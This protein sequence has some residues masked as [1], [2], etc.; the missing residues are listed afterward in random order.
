MAEEKDRQAQT[1]QDAKTDPLAAE[2]VTL[3]AS[4]LQG[5]LRG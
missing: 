4:N 1:S 5:Q 3:S 2:A